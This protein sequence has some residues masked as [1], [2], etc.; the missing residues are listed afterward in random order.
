M[1]HVLDEL[2]AAFHATHPARRPR[3]IV[4]VMELRAQLEVPVT[5][6]LWHAIGEQLACVMPPLRRRPDGQWTFPGRCKSIWELAGFVADQHPDWEPPCRKNLADWREAQVFSRVRAV[7]VEALNVN[8]EE[9]VRTAT[10]QGDL[11]AE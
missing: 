5:P 2:A 6:R 11:G 8:P 1:K 3:V 4:T 7:L 10:L 9:V